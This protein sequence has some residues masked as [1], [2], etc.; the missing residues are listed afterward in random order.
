MSVKGVW[1]S[2]RAVEKRARRQKHPVQTLEYVAP[3]EHFGPAPARTH[4]WALPLSGELRC[5]H[6]GIWAHLELRGQTNKHN[7]EY[8]WAKEKQHRHVYV[9]H[10]NICCTGP[11]HVTVSQKKQH[12]LFASDHLTNLEENCSRLRPFLLWNTDTKSSHVETPRVLF[13]GVLRMSRLL[14]H[15]I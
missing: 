7:Y 9:S 11:Y 10:F 4:C 12:F 1:S 13:S 8:K 3:H 15:P 2:H 5:H 6:R 14:L